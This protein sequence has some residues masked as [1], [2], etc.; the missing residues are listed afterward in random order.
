MLRATAALCLASYVFLQTPGTRIVV[1]HAAVRAG[2]NATAPIV[3]NVT[4][5]DAVQIKS[6]QESWVEV[7]MGDSRLAL[8]DA[9]IVGWLPRCALRSSET[10]AAPKSSI[11]VAADVPGKTYW[12]TSAT[13]RVVPI[14]QTDTAPAALAAGSS[15]ATALNGETVLPDPR[16]GSVTRV[17]TLPRSALASATA[18]AGRPLFLAI[19]QNVVGL[20]AQSFTPVIVRLI[21][22]GDTFLVASG[23]GRADA[24][25]R[26]TAD[27][28]ISRDIKYETVATTPEG[29]AVGMVKV[30]PSAAL[31]AGAYALMLRPIYLQ[32]YAG[33]R[34]FS[35]EGEG[36]AFGQAWVFTVR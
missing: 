2:A 8:A 23:T 16:S 31:A 10:C 3:A 7:V 1:A 33:T 15:I 24:P 14:A 25:V 17:W 29:G 9:R 27:W 28:M 30:R 6:E 18:L 20:S 5:G 11:S 13:L 21:P 22:A 32:G 26:D 12:L 36:L 34:V 35:D 19:Y 4:Y